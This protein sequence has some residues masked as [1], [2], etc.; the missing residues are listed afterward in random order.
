[1]VWERSPDTNSWKEVYRLQQHDSG[2]GLVA[3]TNCERFLLTIG[4]KSDAKV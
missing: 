4:V 3:F 2:V 1:M